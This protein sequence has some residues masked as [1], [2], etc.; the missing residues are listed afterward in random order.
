M[1][2][3]EVP[4]EVSP[5]YI[6]QRRLLYAVDEK[7]EYGAA[8]SVG[9]E[10][11]TEA[12]MAAVREI[13]RQRDDAWARAR[14][15]DTSPL[16]YHMFRRRMDLALLAQTSG[17]WQWRVRRHLR[18]HIFVRLPRRILDRYAEALGLSV[19]ELTRLPDA[20]DIR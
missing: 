18:P 4:Q 14:R 6:G 1:K 20:P 7:G 8:L 3:D 10:V 15:G 5:V 16:E 9:W 13:E 19:P 11:E 12:T 17:F 2:K